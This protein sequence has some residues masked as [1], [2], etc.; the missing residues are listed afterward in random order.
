[1]AGI[2]LSLSL[3]KAYLF[4]DQENSFAIVTNTSKIT[5]CG[6]AYFSLLRDSCPTT[7]RKYRT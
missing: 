6:N 3:S 1:M 2:S 5:V 7:Y 4:E